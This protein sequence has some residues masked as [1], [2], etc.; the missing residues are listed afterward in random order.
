MLLGGA[1]H[2]EP[3]PVLAAV[4]REVRSLDAQVPVESITTLEALIDG[5][6]WMPKM[7]A[8]LLAAFGLLALGLASVGIYGL[9]AYSMA[10]RQREIGLRM[11]LG[12]GRRDVLRLMLRQALTLVAIGLGLGFLGALLVSRA[13]S[14]ILDGLSVADPVSFLGA[15]G[16]LGAV[17]LLASYL[18][19][20]RA[21][22]VDPLVALR[23][24]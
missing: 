24:A 12:A 18:P 21:S 15:A 2:G 8:G 4:Q 7:A 17:A 16:A 19:A 20:R 22:R 1:V 10:R 14:S 9:I 5:S 3:A 6:L 23:E 11:A 13:A